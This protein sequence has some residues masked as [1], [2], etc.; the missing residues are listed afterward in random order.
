MGFHFKPKGTQ[1]NKEPRFF[2]S[3]CLFHR[4]LPRLSKWFCMLDTQIFKENMVR[5]NKLPSWLKRGF[6]SFFAP[7][8]GATILQAFDAH[9]H[10][11]KQVCHCLIHDLFMIPRF[12]HYHY[13]IYMTCT[14]T[15]GIFKD[16]MVWYL[17]L[18]LY[19]H[20]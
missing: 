15:I 4:H 20:R 2:Q 6:N 8:C 1:I 16:G 3:L 14:Q 7:K 12:I 13:M 19:L 9:L 18:S 10:G 17:S 11:F 5:A